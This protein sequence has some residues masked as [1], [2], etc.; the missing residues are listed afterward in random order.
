MNGMVVFSFAKRLPG[1]EPNPCNVRLGEAAIR[2]L[3]SE[4]EPI[5]V[6]AQW[7][8]AR[9][10]KANGVGVQHVVEDLDA[11]YLDTE[12]VWRDARTIFREVDLADVI[13][14]AQ[15]FLQMTKVVQIMR[16][17]GFRPVRRPIGYIGFDNDQRN[18]QWWTRGP[19]RL[20]GGV[21]K[22]LTGRRG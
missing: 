18:T 11:G 20:V 22:A 19:L 5:S 12:A 21:R 2:I 7:E 15:P 14:V 8:V 13:P 16:R 4:P 17:D 10:L 9:H 6:V 3:S 1:E